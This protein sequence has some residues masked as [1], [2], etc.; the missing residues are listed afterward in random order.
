MLGST[1][2]EIVTSIPYLFSTI[3]TTRL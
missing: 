1:T 3:G 2:S